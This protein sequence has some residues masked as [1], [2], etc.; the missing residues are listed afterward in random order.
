MAAAHA[1]AHVD[2][3]G[4]CG[5]RGRKDR[6]DFHDGIG[7]HCAGS[8]LEFGLRGHVGPYSFVSLVWRRQVER[9]RVCVRSSR[10]RRAQ[11]WFLAF[12]VV[13]GIFVGGCLRRS[14]RKEHVV[15]DSVVE[16]LRRSPSG[17][18]ERI[19]GDSRQTVERIGACEDNVTFVSCDSAG[20]P[21]A[22]WTGEMDYR[23]DL[24]KPPN[25]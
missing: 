11:C 19:G 10:T 20:H 24:Q 8:E 5:R 18:R 3:E 12:S 13:L 15:V 7:G 22:K 17:V 25:R 9:R 21:V 2:G 23:T 4:W 6:V 14:Q 1:E 16:V